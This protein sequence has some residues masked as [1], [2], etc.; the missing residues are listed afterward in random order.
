MRVAAEVEVWNPSFDVTPAA[1]LEGILTERGLVPRAGGPSRGPFAVRP[2]LVQLGLIQDAQQRAAADSGGATAPQPPLPAAPGF[3]QLDGEKVKAYVGARPHLARHLGDA[4]SASDWDVEEVGDGNLNFVFILRGPGGA[5]CLKQAPPY[6]RCVGEGWPLGQERVRIE[7]AALAEQAR[8][9]PA[10]VPALHHFDGP[11]CLLVMAYVPPPHIILRKG[12]TQ[13]HT[14]PALAAHLA[15]LLAATLFNTSRL[16]LPGDEFRRL[17][18]RFSN[19]EMC[20]LTEQVIFTDPYYAARYNRCTSPQLDADARALHSDAAAKAAA[21]ALKAKFAERGQAL[22]HGDLHTG[23]LMVSQDSTFAIDPEFAFVGPMAFDLGKVLA[24]LLLAFFAADGHASAADPRRA[25]RQ[26]LLDTAA[27]VWDGFV[28]EFT[29]LWEQRGGEGDAYPS[30]LFGDAAA[31]GA[32]ARREAQ[33]AFFAD[34]WRDCVGFAGA[35]MVR[36]IVGIAH[37][38]DMEAIADA[39]ARAACERRALRFGRRLLVQ[40]AEEFA[41]GPRL[42]TA[43]AD[44]ARADNARPFFEL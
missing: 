11:M 3:E 43:A 6:V 44:A 36:R 19:A 7:A 38:E 10:H 41:G 37:V 15:T 39:D 20:A 14:Y 23:S 5:L 18:A 16:A 4:S 42:V 24:N 31:G 13:G 27:G 35:V 1:L 2:W 12:L 9:C 30:E 40:G 29:S 22:V 26:W 8:H 21:A 32:E 34:V 33:R 17:A 25:Q 28:A